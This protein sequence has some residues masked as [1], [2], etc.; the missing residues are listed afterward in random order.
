MDFSSSWLIPSWNCWCLTH[1]SSLA[2]AVSHLTLSDRI[3]C[4]TFQSLLGLEPLEAHP[5]LRLAVTALLVPAGT[6]WECCRGVETGCNWSEVR[7]CS[8]DLHAG[9][10]RK[11]TAVSIPIPLCLLIPTLL[12]SPLLG[13]EGQL[14]VVNS[15]LLRCDGPVNLG[16]DLPS[17]QKAFS[18]KGGILRVLDW[19]KKNQPKNQKKPTPNERKK[20]KKIPTWVTEK[21]KSG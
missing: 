21:W 19:K 16:Q 5:S 8:C 18:R 9:G 2:Q 6:A 13:H 11:R 7:A 1:H 14:L 3:L 20:S 4:A 15:H 10:Q 17:G 12:L